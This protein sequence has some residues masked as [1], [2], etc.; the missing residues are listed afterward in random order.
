MRKARILIVDDAVAVR[1]TLAQLFAAEPG[2]D[3]PIT[4]ANGRIALAKIEHSRP[5]VV[6]LDVEMPEMDGFQTLAAI[7]RADA[8]LP[9]VMFSSLTERG[10][11][12]TVEA[13]ALGATDYATKPSLSGSTEAA[14]EQLRTELLPKVRA[15]CDRSL[16]PAHPVILSTS[17]MP[18]AADVSAPPR[19]DQSRVEIV[20]I[21]ISTGGPNALTA[22]LP[23]LPRGLPVPVLVVQHIPGAFVAPLADRL[24]SK[25]GLAARVATD[26]EPVQP[27]TVLFAP[28]DRHLIVSANDGTVRAR[29]T[30]T[31]PENSCR[32][33]VDPLFRSLA[34]VYGAGVL[35]VIMTGMGKDGVAGCARIRRAGGR[36]IAQDEATSVVWG[37]P[38]QVV[39]AGLADRVLPLDQLGPEIVRL[40]AI[41]RGAP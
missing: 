29:L 30:E 8:T 6:I 31:S 3:T 21:G 10:A 5:D 35:A 2:F 9:V 13:L 28:G 11:P 37:M 22:V 12:A 18:R 23:S 15:L 34:E 41:G 14:I 38:G 25:M 40:V 19:K 33:A 17:P 26:G 24:A 39:A 32:P 16:G 36:V 7:R 20:A 27:G 1:Q 4:A